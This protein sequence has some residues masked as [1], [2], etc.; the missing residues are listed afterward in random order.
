M[1]QRELQELLDYNPNTGIFTRST[2][3]HKGRWKKGSIVGSL[4][5]GGYLET[6]INNRRYLL[7]RLAFLYMEGYIPEHEVDHKNGVR[8]DNRWNNLRHV[9]AMCNSQN[10]NIRTDNKLGVTGISV[11]LDTCKYRAYI[12]INNKTIGLGDNHAS[13]LEAML[14]RLT[15]EIWHPNWQCNHRNYLIESIKQEWCG[16]NDRC[17]I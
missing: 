5:S 4:H 1:D 16:F 17:L 9:G 3:N 8:T 7:H 12:T 11:R 6:K 2:S 10:V 13:L 14:H 15:C